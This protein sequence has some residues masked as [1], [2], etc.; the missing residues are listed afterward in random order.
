[1]KKIFFILLFISAGVIIAQEVK[2]F[3]HFD[4]GFYGGINFNETSNIGGDFLVEFKTYLI[5]SLQLKAAF[6]YLNT[7]EPFTDT[8]RGIRENPNI[9][10][11]P[12]YF[13][14]KYNYENKVYDMF[15]VSLGFQYTFIQS[16]FS[17]YVTVDAVYNFITG[18]L[19]T[20][21]SENWTYN[22]YE[23]IPDEFKQE[24]KSVELPDNSFGVMLGAGTSYQLSSKLNLD[25][26]YFFKYDS[27]IVN[28]HHIVVG[29]Y[30]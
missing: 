5:P 17:P 12:R 27:E 11:L 13:V 21:P 10:S 26:R 24:Q 6:G 25:L 15:P 18:S 20:S 2:P 3:S 4:I 30:F 1:M 7:S 23:E 9:D 29:I 16:V 28:T 19:D 8:V 22:S 14:S